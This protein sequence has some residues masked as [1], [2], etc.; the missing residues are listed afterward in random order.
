M[1]KIFD[2]IPLLI[3]C[4]VLFSGDDNGIIH[5][6]AFLSVVS[7]S[8]LCQYCGK[9]R[10]S[11]CAA[12]AYIIMCFISPRFLCF[13]P[14]IL[15]DILDDKRY[16]LCVGAGAA[17]IAAIANH[18]V[19]RIPLLLVYILISVILQQRT[20]AFAALQGEYI[21]TRDNS[22][23]INLL[24]TEKNRQL[25]ENQDYEIHLATLRERNRIAREIHDNVG[26][27]LSR[28]ILQLGALQVTCQDELQQQSL[29]ALSVTINSAMTSIR[30][31]VHDLH[32]DSVDLRQAVTEAAKPL[33][34]NGLKTRLELSFSENIPNNIKFSFIS[35][36]KEGISNII[37]HSSADSAS[38]ILREHPA[39]YQL[40]IE[41]NGKCSGGVSEN[42]IG[43][44]NMRERV[45]ELG[46]IIHINSGKDG[47]KIFITIK[48]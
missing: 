35:I 2:K 39:F 10:A 16:F 30:Q 5:I 11:L 33:E 47:F 45:K 6:I 29:E 13:L 15:Y 24:L 31:S 17:L 44:S 48:K 1:K 32:D 34:G 38:I 4:C 43:L 14:V 20:S 27:I 8:A 3:C 22:A 42:G 9:G 23:E 18:S 40:M 19:S 21:K 26:H 25:R 28:S 12:A 7:V 41:D 46:G 37:R 36:V